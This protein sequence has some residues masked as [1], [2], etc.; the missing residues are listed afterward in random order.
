VNRVMRVRM[1][2]GCVMWSLALAAFSLL[3]GELMRT[4]FDL[5]AVRES[6]ICVAALSLSVMTMMVLGA[7]LICSAFLVKNK[8]SL[9]GVFAKARLLFLM[10]ANVFMLT[11]AHSQFRFGGK[12][13]ARPSSRKDRGRKRTGCRHLDA[14]NFWMSPANSRP[15]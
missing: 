11:S 1:Y 9:L 5:A 10:K 8:R 15:Q 13:I 14:S 3:T 4:E 6:P 12:M 7:T 2:S